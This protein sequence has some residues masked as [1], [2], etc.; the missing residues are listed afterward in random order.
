M[1]LMTPFTALAPQSVAPGP[2]MT[3]MRSMCSSTRSCAS[4]KTPEK[5]GVYTARP[6]TITS[7]LLARMLEKPRALTT[8]WKASARAT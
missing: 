8:Y 6:S 1:M 7:I 4:Q 3:S 5:S 2:L